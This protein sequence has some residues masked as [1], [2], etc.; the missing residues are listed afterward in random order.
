MGWHGRVFL[1]RLSGSSRRSQHA[2][3]AHCDSA[4]AALIRAPHLPAAAWRRQAGIARARG[5]VFVYIAGSAI[6]SSQAPSSGG[7]AGRPARLVGSDVRLTKAGSMS[8]ACPALQARLAKGGGS[9]GDR[10]LLA[11]SFEFLGRPEDATR[12]RIISCPPCR[13]NALGGRF[14]AAPRRGRPRHQRRSD[15]RRVAAREGAGGRNVLH[16]GQ[17]GRRPGR[18]GRGVPSQRRR[19]AGPLQTGRFPIDDAREKSLEM[20]AASRSRPAFQRAARRM[21]AAGDLQGTRGVID[22]ADRR[23]LKILI[24]HVIS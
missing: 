5:G 20:P 11:K 13:T 16:R 9:A 21:P 3:G 22:P 17:V 4:L 24:D 7:N 2:R 23:P 14:L 15:A 18:A 6:P 19:M 10:E 12:A 8:S 1:W